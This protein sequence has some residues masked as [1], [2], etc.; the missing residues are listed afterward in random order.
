MPEDDEAG[1]TLNTLLR[2]FFSN[3]QYMQVF[4]DESSHRY[5]HGQAEIRDSVSI[6]FQLL[7]IGQ[8]VDHFEDG[9]SFDSTVSS[10]WKD[11]FHQFISHER[12]NVGY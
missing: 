11:W 12:H 3:V 5:G 10:S 2:I 9:V 6:A 8:I 7:Q 4:S 1:F